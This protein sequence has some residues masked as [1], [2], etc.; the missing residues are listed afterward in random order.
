[1][2]QLQSFAE[3]Q[4]HNERRHFERP[5]GLLDLVVTELGQYPKLLRQIRERRRFLARLR[6]PPRGRPSRV[7]GDRRTVVAGARRTSL[8][9]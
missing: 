1:M 3:A 6:R 9:S 4:L 5:T 7:C 8:T 2:A